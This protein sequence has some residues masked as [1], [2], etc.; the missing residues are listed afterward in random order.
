[1]RSG[2]VRFTSGWIRFNKK[3]TAHCITISASMGSVS[4]F[5]WPHEVWSVPCIYV[6]FCTLTDVFGYAIDNA[7]QVISE[8]GA[9]GSGSGNNVR[10]AKEYKENE[11]GWGGVRVFVWQDVL[12][13]RLDVKSQFFWFNSKTD[14]QCARYFEW[15]IWLGS[16]WGLTGGVFYWVTA[17]TTW[18]T[19][20]TTSTTT[21]T[22][23]TTNLTERV[24]TKRWWC[25]FL[26]PDMN[27]LSIFPHSLTLDQIFLWTI[28]L[29][30]FVVSD[31]GQWY[32]HCS[33]AVDTKCKIKCWFEMVDCWSL[34]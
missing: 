12:T 7:N 15:N 33:N 34:I 31:K 6:G 9:R 17:T 16:E 29:V 28:A 26:V 4:Q 30:V 13:D 18:D 5:S 27:P 19:A 23:C 22:T 25:L 1:M 11:D 3:E 20:T 8:W 2:Q 10:Q 24:H 32:R 14:P 21:T